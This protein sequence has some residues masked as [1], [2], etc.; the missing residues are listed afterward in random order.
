MNSPRNVELPPWYGQRLFIGSLNQFI[1][2]LT[3]S[4]HFLEKKKKEKII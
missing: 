4:Q 1:A 2:K 3:L